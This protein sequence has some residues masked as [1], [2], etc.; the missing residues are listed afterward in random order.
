MSLR[1]PNRVVL[2]CGGREYNDYRRVKMMLDSLRPAA[3][4]HGCARGADAMASRY[5][6]VRGIP[7]IRVPANWNFY[8]T[9]AGSKRNGWMV[10]FVKVTLV[11]A[12]P[13]GDGTANM[14]KTA[15]LAGIETLE[16]EG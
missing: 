10:Q 12:F 11:L 16:V 9:G 5:A 3:I 7:E 1:N 15:R 4:V 6:Q 2:V 13:G 8:D 14:V